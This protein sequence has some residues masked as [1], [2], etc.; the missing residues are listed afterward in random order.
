MMIKTGG[1][2]DLVLVLVLALALVPALVPVLFLALLLFPQGG[3]LVLVLALVLALL[4]E[5]ED[6]LLLHGLFLLCYSS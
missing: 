1:G 4:Q 6:V 2:V 5:R 3:L